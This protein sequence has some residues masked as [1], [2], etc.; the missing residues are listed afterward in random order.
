MSTMKVSLPGTLE[1]FVDEQVAGGG[2][3]MCRE[4]VRALIRDDH[5]RQHLRRL[6]NLFRRF[7]GMRPKPQ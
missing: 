1:T 2:Y 4:Y 5:D 3:R 7:A 6:L